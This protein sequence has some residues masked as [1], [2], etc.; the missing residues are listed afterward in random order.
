MIPSR[1]EVTVVIE[2]GLLTQILSVR[3][4]EFLGELPKDKRAEHLKNV[5][6]L[7]IYF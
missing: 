1:R 2:W 3:S 7:K 4:A 6:S 5:F